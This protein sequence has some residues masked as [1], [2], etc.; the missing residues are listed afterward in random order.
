VFFIVLNLILFTRGKVTRS[1]ISEIRPDAP[2]IKC[3]LATSDRRQRTG[4]VLAVLLVG[5][6]MI[7][8]CFELLG[9]CDVWPAWGLYA[10][11][12]E[13]LVIRVTE[14]GAAK[15]PPDWRPFLGGPDLQFLDA[16]DDRTVRVDTAALKIVR[17]PVYP[18]NRFLI[19]IALQL[20]EESRFNRD[21]MSIVWKSAA[22]RWTGAREERLLANLDEIQQAADRCRFNA[23][24]RKPE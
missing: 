4:D 5:W 8:P 21:E 22:N 1:K 18:A 7:W 11:H 10:Q 20:A 6:V 2:D 13:R 14:S 15:L 23:R 16:A 12:G 24:P 19:G 9:L 3:D 17:A